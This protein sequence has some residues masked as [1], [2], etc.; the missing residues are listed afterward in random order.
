MKDKKLSPGSTGTAGLCAL[1]KEG[2]R[3]GQAD[4]EPYG[5]VSTQLR[6]LAQAK[7]A[8]GLLH[9]AC[10]PVLGHLFFSRK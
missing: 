9:S 3:Q 6:L 2:W 7:T 4:W 5:Q 1:G 10:L 8:A